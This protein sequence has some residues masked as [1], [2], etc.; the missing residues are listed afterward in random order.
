[1][2]LFSR[3]D[4]SLNHLQTLDDHAAN[5]TDVRFLDEASLMLSISSDRSVIIRQAVK[6]EAT[7]AF[8]MVRAVML[9]ASPVSFNTVPTD[10]SM[11]VVSTMDRQVHK[12]DISS[13]RILSFKPANGSSGDTA[14]INSLEV[15]DID[16][17][18]PLLLG[19]SSTDKTI[20]V[21]DYKNG[22]LLAKEYGQTPMSAISMISNQE[23]DESDQRLSLITC[24]YDG[25][26]GIWDLKFQ[27]QRPLHE[28]EGCIE[29]ESPVKV[30]PYPVKPVRK[31]LSKIEVLDMQRSLETEK[32]CAT[33]A[34]TS[35]LPSH[36]HRKP[37]TYSVAN[38]SRVGLVAPSSET[39]VTAAILNRRTSQAGISNQQNGHATES[40]HRKALKAHPSS[41]L[42]DKA[43]KFQ[44]PSLDHRRRSKSAANLNKLNDMAV[45]LCESLQTFRE[46]IM[47]S[48]AEKIDPK[49]LVAVEIELAS[50]ARAVS[51]MTLTSQN[52][53]FREDSFG[54]YLTQMIDK[55]LAL[56]AKSLEVAQ[57][58]VEDNTD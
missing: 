52:T 33:P 50:T 57:S 12:I 10:P 49:T 41:P 16:N 31:I 23:T 29:L 55:R 42:T 22:I 28:L 17:K 21:Y 35:P 5:V 8:I 18:S 27:H 51:E 39:H 7:F 54:D 11:V 32:G 47:P 14:V 26:I 25:T 34:R 1:M 30:A 38:S 24:G 15:H 20:R 2:Q 9:K 56:K 40:F 4:R 19:V 43:P 3:H 46:R 36:I 58:T 48:V 37:S 6:E 13:G 53:P 44:R 45:D